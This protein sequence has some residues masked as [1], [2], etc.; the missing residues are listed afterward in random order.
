MTKYSKIYNDDSETF[1]YAVDA[2]SESVVLCGTAA[3]GMSKEMNI[4]FEDAANTIPLG[5]LCYMALQVN[6]LEGG[7]VI[8]RLDRQ[9]LVR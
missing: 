8:V 3:M 1:S 6:N 4:R 9:I 2:Q 5:N 7:S